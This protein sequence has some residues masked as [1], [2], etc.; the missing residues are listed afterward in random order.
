MSRYSDIVK[1]ERDALAAKKNY[2]LAEW[3]VKMIYYIAMLNNK[4]MENGRQEITL[5]LVPGR[6]P[7]IIE[8]AKGD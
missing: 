7:T 6:P 2:R 5:I 3:Q 8:K 4:A 1:Q